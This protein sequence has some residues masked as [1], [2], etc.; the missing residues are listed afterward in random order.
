MQRAT[1]RHYAERESKLKISIWSLLLEI[2]NHREEEEKR[3]VRSNG[4]CQEN[5]A[6]QIN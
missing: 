2:G 6:H 5:M 4:R 1:A 3:G